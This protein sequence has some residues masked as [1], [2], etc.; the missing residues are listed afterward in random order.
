MQT[1]V[2]LVD[3]YRQDFK[4]LG[5]IRLPAMRIKSGSARKSLHKAECVGIS[6]ILVEFITGAAGL[7]TGW[8]N[9][10]RQEV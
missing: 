7:G 1:D 8:L 4:K 3:K 6:K 9:E 2:L 5:N 10:G